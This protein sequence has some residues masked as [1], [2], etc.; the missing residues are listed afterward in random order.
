MIEMEPICTS[1]AASVAVTGT[2]TDIDE[3]V[4]RNRREWEAAAISLFN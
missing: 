4:E 1:I 3:E 2:K